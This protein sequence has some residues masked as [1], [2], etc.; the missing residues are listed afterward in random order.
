MTSP[1]LLKFLAFF[2]SWLCL[3]C[4]CF[5]TAVEAQAAVESDKPVPLKAAYHSLTKDAA[6]GTVHYQPKG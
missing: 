3:F 2:F 4:G 5:S 6:A 1:P